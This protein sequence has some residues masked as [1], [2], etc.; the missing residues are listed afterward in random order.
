[1]G[2]ISPRI[3]R[4]ANPEHEHVPAQDMTLTLL[5]LR[6]AIKTVPFQRAFGGEGII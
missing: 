6:K 1:M 3:E 5:S 4:N 2:L